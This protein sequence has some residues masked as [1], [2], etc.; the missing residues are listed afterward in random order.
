MSKFLQKYDLD[1]IQLQNKQYE[2]M[3]DGDDAFFEALE[4]D[5]I[6]QGHFQA[7]VV[8]D[9]SE[10][11]IHTKF[12]IK[13]VVELICDRSLDAFEYGF[14]AKERMI[15]KLGD[16]NEELDADMCVIRRD[17]QSINLASII[18][19]YIGSALPVKKLHPRYKT[20]GEEEYDEEVIGEI[21]YTS[22]KED[23][24]I[25]PSPQKETVDARWE[26]LKK[27]K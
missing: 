19:E 6:Q 10:T 2:Y 8:V 20:D 23:D 3:F 26:V 17:T 11:M 4:Q 15:Y 5:L 21:I 25:V 24:E 27:L 12:E 18:F 7:K 13:G 1:I 9:K 16:H 22:G 14:E